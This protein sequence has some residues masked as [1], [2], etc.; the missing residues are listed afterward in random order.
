[1]WIVIRVLLT[2]CNN[3]DRTRST[4]LLLVAVAS[5]D[6]RVIKLYQSIRICFGL[7]WETT[8]FVSHFEW[9]IGDPTTR[10]H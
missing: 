1:M 7:K 8:R 10:L 6:S 9:R 2:L 4:G 3:G 5:L